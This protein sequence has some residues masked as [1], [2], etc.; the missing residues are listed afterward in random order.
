MTVNELIGKW[1][2]RLKPVMKLERDYGGMMS[3]NNGYREV[4]D[5]KYTTRPA[6]IVKIEE[7]VVYVEWLNYMDTI[8]KEILSPEYNDNF[9]APVDMEFI[10]K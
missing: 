3:F 9:W 7:G 4:P 2:V 10:K 8:T 5:G 1:A 6:K